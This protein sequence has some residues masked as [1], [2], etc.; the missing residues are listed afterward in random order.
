MFYEPLKS[1]FEALFEIEV[2]IWLSI[3]NCS[4]I[5]ATMLAPSKRGKFNTIF[6]FYFI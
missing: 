6:V 2:P 1:L 3:T 4:K 5:E